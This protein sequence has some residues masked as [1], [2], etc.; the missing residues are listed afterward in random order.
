[1]KFAMPCTRDCTG[2]RVP[3][4]R[5]HNL[6]GCSRFEKDNAMSPLVTALLCFGAFVALGLIVKVAMGMWMKRQ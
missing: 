6:E 3:G 5:E 1:M 2:L 4:K